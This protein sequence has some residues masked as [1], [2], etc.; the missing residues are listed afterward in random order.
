MKN[1]IIT[2]SCS[3]IGSA[4]TALLASEG[5]NITGWCRCKG[6]DLKKTDIDFGEIPELDAVI[7]VSEVGPAPLLKI[8]D[9]V[10]SRLI[11]RKGVFVGLSSVWHLTHD[12]AYAESKR[13]QEALMRDMAL[14]SP[15]IRVNCLRLGHIAGEKRGSRESPELL[16]EIPLG[17]FGTAQDVA[18]AVSFIV[19]SGW[20]T[21]S[22]LTLDGGMSL[23]LTDA[24]GWPIK[25][26]PKMSFVHAIKYPRRFMEYCR[27]KMVGALFRM[28]S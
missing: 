14:W 25:N 1:A 9:A 23:K 2:G 28:L 26:Y 24:K 17:R 27:F 18:E 12:G 6:F 21:G 13:E 7:H 10:K 3:P 19:R 22:T 15:H 16:G 5:F 20:M 8:W 4:V 11:A